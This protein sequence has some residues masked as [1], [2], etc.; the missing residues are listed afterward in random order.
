[1]TYD[2]QKHHRRSIRLRGYD[3][4][5][6]GAYFVTI[7]TRNHESIFGQ[8]MEG[9]MVLNE[10]GKVVVECWCWLERQYEYVELDEYVVMP[11][12]LHGIIIITDARRGDPLGRPYQRHRPHGPAPGSIGSI[13]GQFKSAATKRINDLRGTTRVSVWQRNYYE[14]VIRNEDELNHLR[15]YILDN[16]VQWNMDE[17]NPNSQGEPLC[18]LK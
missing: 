17:N 14:R 9:K 7:C 10:Y 2:A 13:V 15:W 18:Q 5:Q 11:N 16:H 12:H 1:M 8:I 3:Y 6:A 4:S